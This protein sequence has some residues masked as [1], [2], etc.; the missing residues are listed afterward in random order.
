MKGLLSDANIEGH[1]RYLAAIL[2]GDIWQEIWASLRLSLQ[3]FRDVGLLEDA[4]DAIVWLWCQQ[5]DVILVT[6]NRNDD[7]PDSLESTIRNQIA[8]NSLPVFTLA[9]PDRVLEDRN[10]A[11]QVVV[12][13]LEYLLD[14]DCVRGAGR[15]YL[16]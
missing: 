16:P 11:E 14:I 5:H 4:S 2:E 3:F 8:M 12:R 15:L 6:A 10:Y 9:D 1:V 7:G 13:M